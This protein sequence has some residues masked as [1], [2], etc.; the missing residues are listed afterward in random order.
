MAGDILVVTGGGEDAVSIEQ[1]ETRDAAKPPRTHRTAPARRVGLRRLTPSGGRATSFPCS[2]APRVAPG[3]GG[4]EVELHPEL[5]A[6]L[7]P[8]L[9]AGLHPKLHREL[10]A[11]LEAGLYLEL[12]AGLHPELE[13]GLEAGLHTELEAR[14]L[15][16]GSHATPPPCPPDVLFRSTVHAEPEDA[17]HTKQ[18]RARVG[19]HLFWKCI[20]WGDPD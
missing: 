15:E 8:E 18:G 9:E 4:L 12:E 17:S 6:E 19:A 16:A 14:M 13:V 3:A 1:V 5:E 7:H 20:D 10:E 2:V 11:G